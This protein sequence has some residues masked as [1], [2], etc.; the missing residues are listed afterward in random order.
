LVE[1]FTSSLEEAHDLRHSQTFDSI[2]IGLSIKQVPDVRVA[3]EEV[4]GV[5]G[6]VQIHIHKFGDDRDGLLNGA[7]TIL[8]DGLQRLHNL[9][10]H[11]SGQVALLFRHH[12]AGRRRGLS[13]LSGHGVRAKE[14]LKP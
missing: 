5:V 13:S 11:L 12:G 8:Q 6:L 4:L 10:S 1:W 3:L 9:L 14:E 2:Q 7:D